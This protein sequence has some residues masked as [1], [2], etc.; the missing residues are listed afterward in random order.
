V[1]EHFTD[2]ADARRAL[3]QKDIYAYLPIPPRP[4]QH[5]QR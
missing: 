3:Q 2:E 4:R 1:T 5:R